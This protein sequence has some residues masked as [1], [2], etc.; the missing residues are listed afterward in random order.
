MISFAYTSQFHLTRARLLW[1]FPPSN[2]YNNAVMFM[3][4]L[5]IK[6]TMSSI[7]RW[8]IRALGGSKPRLI[9]A[10]SAVVAEDRLIDE[11]SLPNYVLQR[12]YPV[13]LGEVFN[14]RYEVLVKLG[15]GRSSTVW[16]AQDLL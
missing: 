8:V 10:R 15:Y 12:Y 13:S 16:L 1:S 7:L 9:R 6:S 5:H 3:V 4:I 14:K 11:E 2:L